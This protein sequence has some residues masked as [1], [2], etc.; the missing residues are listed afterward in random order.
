VGELLEQLFTNGAYRFH[1]HFAENRTKFGE[2]PAPRHQKPACWRE[3][4]V[5]F[6]RRITHKTTP[7]PPKP[8]VSHI[9]HF[10]VGLLLPSVKEKS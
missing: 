7:S 10:Q 9:A 5:G 2:P 8:R 6:S 3:G 4:F 1:R